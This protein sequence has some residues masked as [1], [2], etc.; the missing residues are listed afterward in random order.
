VVDNFKGISTTKK[1]LLNTPFI[2][3]RKGIPR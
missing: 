2:I 1:R 3:Q